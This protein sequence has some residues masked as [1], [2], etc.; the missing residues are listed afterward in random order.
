MELNRP[1]KYIL[2]ALFFGQVELQYQMPRSAYD[3][4]ACRSI[5]LWRPIVP[6]PLEK[7]YNRK[8]HM[9]NTDPEWQITVVP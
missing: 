5:N 3:F 2:F 6:T 9:N 7:I 1:D 4:E 8:K